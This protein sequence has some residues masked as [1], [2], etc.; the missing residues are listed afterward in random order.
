MAVARTRTMLSES[1]DNF[2]APVVNKPVPNH[3][4]ETSEYALN[5]E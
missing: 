2:V 4:S 1:F 3:L 5:H